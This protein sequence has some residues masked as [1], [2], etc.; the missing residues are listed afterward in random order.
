VHARGV[1]NASFFE[2][3][4]ERGMVLTKNEKQNKTACL[5]FSL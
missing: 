4:M 2:T 1:K 3:F 5:L